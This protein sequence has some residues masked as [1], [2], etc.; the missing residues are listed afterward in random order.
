[1]RKVTVWDPVV[2]TF[3]WFTV[4]VVLVNTVLLD[5]GDVHEALG[6]AV[7]ALLFVRLVWGFVGT[8]YARFANFFPTRARIREHFAGH[9]GDGQVNL[10]HNPLGAIMIFNLILTLIGVCLTG[11]FMTT[12]R[13]WGSEFMEE[14]HE[15][16]VVY[17]LISVVFHV[18]GVL[19][20]SVRSHVNLVAVMVTGRRKIDDAERRQVAD[21]QT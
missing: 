2:R 1:M 13:F 17:L 9:S 8:S 20:E 21:N 11:H 6:Y 18:A 3:H 15:G 12:D 5:E 10:G 4:A 16:F 7:A 19:I 14:L